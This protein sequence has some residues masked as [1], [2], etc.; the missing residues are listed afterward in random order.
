MASQAWASPGQCN[1]NPPGTT[2]TYNLGTA[3]TKALVS[4][5][6]ASAGCEQIN[7][8]FTNFTWFPSSNG[9]AGASVGVQFT[10]ANETSTDMSLSGAWAGGSGSPDSVVLFQSQLN[11]ADTPPPPNTNWSITGLNLAVSG[12]VAPAGQV[13]IDMRF[14]TDATSCDSSDGT[15][16]N[17]GEILYRTLDGVLQDI[18]CYNNGD[19]SATRPCTTPNIGSSN[20]FGVSLDQGVQSIAFNIDIRLL[21]GGQPTSLSGFDITFQQTA[22][23]PEPSGFVLMGVGLVL[24]TL[25]RLAV[26]RRS[27]ALSPCESDS[28][29]KIGALARTHRTQL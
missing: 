12:A 10:G 1:P 17:F 22:E 29:H 11:P 26:R 25:A 24:I 14:C 2:V 21:N 5:G 7:N 15:H 8:E 6:G 27:Q 16:G 20:S 23:A 28:S 9:P 19:S 4:P 18:S 13:L 3:G